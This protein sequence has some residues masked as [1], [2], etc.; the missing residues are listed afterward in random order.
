[1]NGFAD[2]VVTFDAASAP[3][4]TRLGVPYVAAPGV[5]C[6]A[7]LGDG[8]P[9]TDSLVSSVTREGWTVWAIGEVFAYRGSRVRPLDRIA[10]DLAGGVAVPVTLDAHAAVFAWDSAAR[11]LHVWIDRMGTVH[12]Y[13][14]GA[15]GRTRVGT[16]Y[17]AVSESSSRELDWIGI[18]GF[19]GLGFFPGDRTWFDDVRV[20]RPATWSVF[21]EG[22]VLLSQGRY[23]DW[24]YSP[25]QRPDEELVDEFDHVFGEAV[26]TQTRSL[27]LI[28][29]VS[30][31]LDSRTVLAA[32]SAANARQAFSY[33]YAS[34]SV[35]SS[36]GSR[37]ATAC[38][39]PIEVFTV[40]PYLFERMDDVVD[41]V[42]GFQGL[43][44]SRQAGVSSQLASMGSRVVGGHWGDVW[45][46]EAGAADEPSDSAVVDLS[47]AKFAKRGR[48]WLLENLC[49]PH[50]QGQPGEAVLRDLLA[51][52]LA[53]IPSPGDSDMHLKIL[54]TEQWS[55]RWTL[56][57]VR[58]YQL[59]VPALFPFYANGVVDFFL[60]VPAA[61]L[62]GRRLQIEYL[63]RCHPEVAAI[64]WQATGVPLAPSR[65]ER[66]AHL[67]SR[68]SSKA[69]RTV[70]RRALPERNWE[71]QFGNPMQQEKLKRHLEGS[72]ALGALLQPP[73]VDDLLREFRTQPSGANGYTVDA[74][75]TIAAALDR[76]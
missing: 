71:I 60:S 2:L 50:L 44:F 35:E 57:S 23:W 63:L 53:R 46:D 5:A 24:S 38:G 70:R 45:F 11:Q 59:A 56:A 13:A 62:G 3:H 42:E 67:A 17:P 48:A 22:G 73:A 41:A 31:G 16:F 75:V 29:P 18:T 51:S 25:R 54:K 21:D 66:T 33:G 27:D 61:R 47:F 12:V 37:V 1:M 6:G 32:T 72:D 40:E 58:S 52:E 28:V 10:D 34:D 65:R 49:E 76:I 8:R 15:R 7:W 26:A 64:P 19:C 20:L 30:G 39:V 74:L 9:G 69:M 55:F 43:C 4:R 14:G 68:I 36:I